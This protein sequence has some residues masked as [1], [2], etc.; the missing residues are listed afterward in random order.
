MKN[1]IYLGEPKALSN[2]HHLESKQKDMQEGNWSGFANDLR[3]L[4]FVLS[5]HL[6][7]PTLENCQ[8]N[9]DLYWMPNQK[10]GIC[11]NWQ[12]NLFQNG[13]F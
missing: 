13:F 7:E 10:K 1:K 2:E 9:M 3:Y 5:L 8:E 6:S 4:Q 12:A 11:E